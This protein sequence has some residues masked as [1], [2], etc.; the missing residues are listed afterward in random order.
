MP[1]W[2]I[3]SKSLKLC[4]KYLRKFHFI[5][6]CCRH[7]FVHFDFGLSFRPSDSGSICQ[8]KCR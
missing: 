3:L 4:C 1:L 6:D 7:E 2:D 8:F 5:F